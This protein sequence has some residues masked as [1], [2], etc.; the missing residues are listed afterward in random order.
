[1]QKNEVFSTF[2][3]IGSSGLSEFWSLNQRSFETLGVVFV[4]LYVRTS[5]RN[6]FSRKPFVT[7]F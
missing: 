5:V 6:A 7:F 3:Q 1:M 4:R 2:L